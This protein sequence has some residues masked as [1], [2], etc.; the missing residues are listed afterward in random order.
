M[1]VSFMTLA[2]MRQGSL[3]AKW[4]PR[5]RDVLEA[6]LA[7]FTVL[8]SDDL[9]CS[10]WAAVRGESIRKGRQISSADAWIAA[11]ALLYDAPLLTHNKSDYLGVSGLRFVD[12]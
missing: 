4:G 2:E 9:L 5:K 7:G 3:D 8:H 11:T 1:V 6:Y 12:V 10:A